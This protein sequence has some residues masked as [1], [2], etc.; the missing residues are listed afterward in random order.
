VSDQFDVE[1]H[2][3]DALA[4]IEMLGNLIV[5]AS[6]HEDRVPQ[7]RIDEILDVAPAEEQSESDSESD[8]EV[9]PAD[10]LSESGSDAAD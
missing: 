2:D 6:E 9:A 3:A 7:E 5:V 10:E 1:V 8:S 4:E